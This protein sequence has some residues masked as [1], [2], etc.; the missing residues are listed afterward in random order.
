MKKAS[1]KKASKKTTSKAKLT[2]V[3]VKGRAAQDA[4]LAIDVAVAE[5]EEGAFAKFKEMSINDTEGLQKIKLYLGAL[6]DVKN[7]LVCHVSEGKLAQDK[8]NKANESGD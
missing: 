4:L 2:A 8:L 3:S 6:Q 7:R 5:I 1:K